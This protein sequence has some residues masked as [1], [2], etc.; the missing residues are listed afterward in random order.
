[1]LKEY[2]CIICPI[3]CEI[4]TDFDE[5]TKAIRG[6]TGAKCPKGESY[7]KQEIIDPQR[8]LQS[9]VVVMN[10]ELPLV[11]VKISSAVSRNYLRNLMERIN[12]LS[13][14]APITIGEII[15]P[16]ILGL[17]VDLVATKTVWLTK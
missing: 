3:G 1:M 9:S 5:N 6:I 12:V 13:V 2:T 7:I 8:T 11:S 10:G 4:T 14:N 15:E 16:N 17:G